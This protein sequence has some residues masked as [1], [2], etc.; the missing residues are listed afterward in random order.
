MTKWEYLTQLSYKLRALPENE[1]SD[2]LEYYEGYLTDAE[3]EATAIAQL[4]S[5]GEVAANILAEYVCKAPYTASAK[6][7]RLSNAWIAILAI[8]ALPVGLPLAMAALGLIIALLAVVFS[9]VVTGGALLLAGIISIVYFPIAV[10]ND[11]AFGMMV[12]GMGLVSLG[13]GI[14][15]AKLSYAM[16]GGFPAIMRYIRRRFGRKQPDTA[17]AYTMGG[18]SNGQQSI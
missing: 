8:F 6:R 10:V 12:G 4:G 9:V 11:F 1:R 14:L 5:P 15:V 17:Y 16:F 3:D 7:R 2:A 18:A 13:L